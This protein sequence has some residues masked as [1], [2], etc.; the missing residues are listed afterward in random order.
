MFHRAL[1]TGNPELNSRDGIA[2]ARHRLGSLTA[3]VQEYGNDSG[4][5]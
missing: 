5:S 2:R 1:N 3:H 4:E